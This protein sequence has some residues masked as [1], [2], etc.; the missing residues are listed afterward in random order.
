MSEPQATTLPDPGAT[1]DPLDVGATLQGKNLIV[2]GTTGFLGKVWLAM[3]LHRYPEVGTIYTVVRSRKT[4]T[5]EERWWAEIVPSPVFD[6]L[7]EQHP[8]FEAWIKSKVVA[9]DG[10]VTRDLLGVDPELVRELGA[11]KGS[12]KE[13][14][15]IVNVA[16]VVDFNPPLDE[17]L[18][19]NAYGARHLIALSRALGDAPIMHTSTCFVVGCRDG[20]TMERN[21]LEFPFPRADELDVSHW[22]AEREIDECSDLVASTRR[23]AEDAPRQSHLLDEA[24]RNLRDRHEPLRGAAL[25]DELERVKRRFVRERLIAAG[26][27][28]ATFWGWPNIYTYTKSI[29]EQVLLSSGLPLTIVRPSIV[30]SAV[31]F[32]KVGWCEGISTSTPIMYLTYQGQQHIPAGEKCYYDAIPVD[33]CSA[34]MIAA[35]AA[36]IAERHEVCYQLCTSDA[37]PLKTRRAGELIGLAKRRYYTQRTKGNALVNM[38]QAHAEPAIV[39]L[40][41][42]ERWSSPQ[43]RKRSEQVAGFLERFRDTPSERFTEPVRKQVASLA[44][45]TANIEMV[46]DAFTPFITAN[47]YRF[48]AKNTRGLMKSLTE[49][50]QAK[51]RWNPE[52]IDWRHYW[53]EIHHKGVEEFSIPLLEDKLRKETKALRRH[54]NLVAMLEDLSDRH[55]HALA[56]QRMA[57]DPPQLSRITYRDLERRSAAVA[58]RLWAAGVRKGDRVALGGRNH[59]AWS[60]VYF[61]ILRCGAA[62]VPVDKD[63]EAG[64]LSV[65]LRKS[66]AKIAVFDEHVVELDADGGELCPRWDL[67]A[68]AAPTHPDDEPEPVAPSVEIGD[69][70]LASVLYTSGTTGDPKGVM[71][72]HENFTALIAALAP[73]FPLGHQDRV[74]SVL[75]LH[76]TFEFTCGMLLPLSRGARV[77]YLDEINGDRMIE[78]LELGQVTAII[79]V[80][81]LWELIERRVLNEV[82]DRGRLSEK[83]FDFALDLNR[84]VGKTLGVDLGRVLFGPVHQQLGGNLKYL[85][86]GAAA[87]PRDVHRTF[88]GL[89][90]HLAEGYGLTE[91]APVLTLSKASPRSK[92]G[93]V[94]K[95]IPGVE[96]KIDKPN[97][98]GV[99]EILARGPNVM[100]GYEGDDEETKKTLT[101]GWL[102]TG[103]LGK[104]DRK[105]RLKIVGRSKEVILSASGENV[106]PDDVEVMLGLPK[107]IK[108]LSIVGIPDR[109]KEGAERVAV[110]AVPD[111]ANRSLDEDSEDTARVDRGQRR[112][113]AEFELR[114]DIGELPRHMRPT[115]IHFTDVDLPRTAT[116]KVKRKEVRTILETLREASEAVA[117]AKASASANDGVGFVRSAI[118]SIARRP[119]DELLPSHDLQNDLAFDSLMVVELTSILEAAAPKL[120]NVNLS[121]LRTIAELEDAVRTANGAKPEPSATRQIE[122]DDEDLYVPDFIRD[123]AKAALTVGQ[124]SFYDR[125]MKV[126]ISGKANIPHN[127]HTLIVANHASHLDMGLAKYA[128][129]GYGS[130]I[131]ALAAE[132]YFFKNKWMR[133]YFENFTNMGALD[134]RSGLRKAIEQAGEHISRGRTV[135][136]FPE[137][138]R[139]TDGVMKEFMP[140]IGH[141]VLN[142]NVDVLPLWLGGTHKALPKGASV[143]RKRSVEVRIGPPLT[144]EQLETRVAGMKRSDA[145]REVAHLAHRAVA[146]LRDGWQLDLER[147]ALDAA[148]AAEAGS[149]DAKPKQAPSQ[150]K[151]KSA[152]TQLFEGLEGRFVPGAVDK[153]TSFY[154]SLGG[155]ADGKWTLALS[156]EAASFRPGRPEGGSADC[157]LK[158]SVEIFE[159][160]VRHSYTPSVAE[161]MAGKV[162][163]NDIALLQVFQKAF[164]L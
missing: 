66:K 92:G 87:L 36:L 53:L 121:D 156:P 142:Y 56:F 122:K 158:T 33:M 112:R 4:I 160:I 10:D 39:P 114:K 109:E 54:D 154:F 41:H 19:V 104:L 105:D 70:D 28:R 37:N 141:L 146:A 102:R 113:E 106:Y 11:A 125:F 83:L 75:P 137:G 147:E 72:T 58:Q 110:L 18:N 155:V 43:V 27:E 150:A 46:F 140:L 15:A 32:P 151:G 26:A 14:A 157:V 61:G 5:S 16:G 65:V 124:L 45:N 138:T 78:G 73:L 129:G 152:M 115:V 69:D 90:L 144:I 82:R 148:A 101:E 84:N 29:G 67:Q 118:A 85:V 79:G 17:A 31:E 6:S 68:T 86:S 103:D 162:K 143:P 127:R 52:D 64:P 116:R 134:R 163:S 80:P 76:H 21:T 34:A 7:R 88:Q 159:K 136:I 30:E 8:D 96:I 20:V 131:V 98:E 161:F 55:E 130:K 91:A 89:G 139:S 94:G 126:K 95:A 3:L 123:P 59:P 63:F 42:Y 9:I 128:L 35:L 40:E 49:A 135:L 74:L 99:G 2:I 22:S 71:L 145:Y 51:L 117:A 164:D 23:R 57:G 93:T 47:E 132:D 97:D 133:A 13:I 81:A 24:K 25:D 111:Y 44:K 149:G 107:F 12:A 38:V 1:L 100:V 48:S 108:E 153:P 77:I 50:D 120:S 60:I 119:V 62:A